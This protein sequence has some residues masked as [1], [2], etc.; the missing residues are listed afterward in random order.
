MRGL[1]FWSVSFVLILIRIVIQI[2]AL[3]FQKGLDFQMG[4][5]NR[6]LSLLGE[7]VKNKKQNLHEITPDKIKV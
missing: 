3:T 5:S 6:N 1:G 7:E 2:E 4:F